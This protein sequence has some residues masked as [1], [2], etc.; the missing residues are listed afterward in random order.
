[1]DSCVG[2]ETSTGIAPRNNEIIRHLINMNLI[3]RVQAG[4]GAVTLAARLCASTTGGMYYRIMNGEAG[5]C[6][7]HETIT[8]ITITISNKSE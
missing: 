7:P 6:L 1:M 2:L 8:P 5:V 3:L 4:A